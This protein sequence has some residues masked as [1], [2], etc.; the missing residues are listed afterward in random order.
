[1]MHPYNAWFEQALTS[2]HYSEA[3]Y[4]QRCKTRYVKTLEMAEDLVTIQSNL[5]VAE[6]GP[7][8]LLPMLCEGTGCQGTAYGLASPTLR[9]NLESYSIQFV[10]WDLN[11]ALEI[12][13]SKVCQHDIVFFLEVIEH[14]LRYPVEVLAEI[15]SLIKPN[16]ILVIST[17]NFL[18]LS[19][20]IRVLTGKSP[21]INPFIRTPDGRNH[22]REFCLP[23]LCQ[24]LELAGLQVVKS[25]TWP[26]YPRAMS[27]LLYLPNRFFPSLHNYMAI[28]ARKML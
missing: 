13:E 28:A 5:S 23:E 9:N 1:M 20:R 4:Y 18:R 12:Q 14:L 8:L 22:L 6:V 21:Y 2:K 24:Y 17:V 25:E 16:G 3:D 15:A 10:E 19:N 26:L 27:S 11:G 7:G